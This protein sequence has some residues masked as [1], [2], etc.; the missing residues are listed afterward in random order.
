MW[1]VIGLTVGIGLAVVFSLASS[2]D[3]Q[4]AAPAVSLP[5]LGQPNAQDAQTPTTETATE[6][7]GELVTGFGDT[8][9][10]VT[11][12]SGGNLGLLTWPVSGLPREVPLPGFAPADVEFDR[13]GRVAAMTTPIVDSE[14][15]LLSFGTPPRVQ[16]M[17]TGVTGFAWHD[18]ET[19]HLAYTVVD[20]DEWLLWTTNTSRVAELVTSDS[21]IAGAVVGWGEWGFAI[22]DGGEFTLLTPE[23]NPVVTLQG[24]LLDSD[25]PWLIVVSEGVVSIVDV[26]GSEV[27]REVDVEPLGEVAAG[28]VSPDRSKVAVMGSEGHMIIPLALS[29]EPTFDSATTGPAQ[30]AWSSDSRFL[31][32]PWF[33]GVLFI[34]TV[35]RG[36]PVAELTR[37]TV[38]AVTAIP[39]R[40]G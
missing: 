29:L 25:Q 9:V 19:G 39:L 33:R 5:D 15:A 34:D 30:L 12:L 27:L 14:G 10:A 16:P 23:G 24:R 26:G 37:H 17:A 11:Q 36:E 32:S 8:L 22:Q 31:V 4:E 6:G 38:V 21:G 3:T 13:S 2:G 40:E 7:V 28:L 1:L 18:T 35:G 20:G